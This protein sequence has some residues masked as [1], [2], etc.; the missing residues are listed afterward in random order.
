MRLMH[1]GLTCISFVALASAVGCGD[2]NDDAVNGAAGTVSIS[3]NGGKSPTGGKSSGG[4]SAGRNTQAGTGGNLQLGG[5]PGLG[6]A[7]GQNDDA[8]AGAGG[9]NEGGSDAGEAGAGGAAGGP[10][11]NIELDAATHTLTATD[12]AIPQALYFFGA[13]RPASS[14]APAS[15]SCVGD[16]L[17]TWPVFYRSEIVSGDGLPVAEFGELLR[18]DGK[19]QTTFKGWPLYSYVD[20]ASAGDR[21]GDGVGSLWHVAVEPFYTVVL[22]SGTF[23]GEATGPYLA[24]ARGH[25]IYRFI[26]DTLGTPN[27]DPVSTC[28]TS[29][30]RK[31]WPVF[32]APAVRAVSSIEGSFK[33]FLRPD[34]SEIQLSYAGI[35]LYW[36]AQDQAPG[37][38]VGLTKPS[39]ALAKP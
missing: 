13:D 18:P 26:G 8:V 29:G 10:A 9:Q 12:G 19:K 16:C 30:C 39:W 27:S 14:T 36:F 21:K 35:P 17:V 22:M 38:L 6:G 37:D 28:T 24:D 11:A 5:T 32:S 3:G 2:D 23:E 25:T 4:S 7:G 20:D 31:A 15:S 33:P 34:T 1:L